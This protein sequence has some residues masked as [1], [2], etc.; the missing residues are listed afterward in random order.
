MDPPL[1]RTR[2]LVLGEGIRV[3]A[4]QGLFNPV[5]AID[6]DG[7]TL[8]QVESPDIVKASCVVLVVVG[9]EY[10]VQVVDTLT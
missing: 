4:P 7:M 8:E 9:K 3:L 5:K 2:I 6:V 1:G 10:G